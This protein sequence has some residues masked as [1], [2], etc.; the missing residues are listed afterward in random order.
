MSNHP[1]LQVWALRILF[2]LRKNIF[3]Y[4]LTLKKKYWNFNSVFHWLSVTCVLVTGV[5]RRGVDADWWFALRCI[6]FYPIESMVTGRRESEDIVSLSSV[7]PSNGDPIYQKYSVVV[8]SLF[9][10]KTPF[11]S[12][13]VENENRVVKEHRRK[14]KCSFQCR[15]DREDQCQ[16]PRKWMIKEEYSVTL[17][18][19]RIFYKN[20]VFWGEAQRSYFL[21]IFSLKCS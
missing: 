15:Y 8:T 6:P 14:C 5:I 9:D 2:G 16:N 12:S 18:T 1:R 21:P 11:C 13:G 17:C 7:A 20:T 3:S 4:I 19:R 10:K